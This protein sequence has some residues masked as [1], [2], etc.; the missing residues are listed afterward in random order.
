MPYLSHV[1]RSAIESGKQ[2]KA[3]NC[4]YEGEG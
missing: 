2:K 4:G 1:N 3:P